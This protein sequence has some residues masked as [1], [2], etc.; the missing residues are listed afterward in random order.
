VEKVRPFRDMTA[1]PVDGRIVE[2]QHGVDQKIVLAYWSNHLRAWIREDAN[3]KRWV[4]KDVTGW[5]VVD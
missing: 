1:A 2:V 3:K 4:L 5:R